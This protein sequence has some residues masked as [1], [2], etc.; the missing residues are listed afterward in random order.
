MPASLRTASFSPSCCGSNHVQPAK[1]GSGWSVN[2]A[3]SAILQRQLEH[4]QLH[5]VQSARLIE[6]EITRRGIPFGWDKDRLAAQRTAGMTV[7]KNGDAAPRLHVQNVDARIV[8]GE[9]N[10][11]GI[12]LARS[13]ARQS[14][15]ERPAAQQLTAGQFDLVD[16]AIVGGE[17][18]ARP[19]DD[20]PAQ[21]RLTDVI[22][23]LRL[24]FVIARRQR[25]GVSG[26]HE[27]QFRDG[28]REDGYALR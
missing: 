28:R 23:P 11:V 7:V 2:G 20:G 21:H 1:R 8:G 9:I 26:Q 5:G 14:L 3:A 25:F 17:I 18:G 24:T 6:D 16:G 4:T 22:L 15:A 27:E 12:T 10:E 13:A 19:D